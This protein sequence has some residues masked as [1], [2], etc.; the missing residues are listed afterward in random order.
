V[1]PT[2]SG[3]GEAPRR[4]MDFGAIS[5]ANGWDLFNLISP[6]HAASAKP[7]T[8]PVFLVLKT[9]SRLN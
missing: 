4:A 5:G 9:V 8:G 1:R 7:P 2:E 3:L 6:I